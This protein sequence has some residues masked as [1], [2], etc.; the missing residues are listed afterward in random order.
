MAVFQFTA[1]TMTTLDLPQSD[2]DLR[3]S[4][5]ADSGDSPPVEGRRAGGRRRK[6]AEKLKEL[7]SDVSEAK[8]VALVAALQRRRSTTESPAHVGKVQD[9]QARLV[10][11]KR[12]IQMLEA[13][14]QTRT[15]EMS[16][17]VAL[18]KEL[19]WAAAPSA[20]PR[21]LLQEKQRRASELLKELDGTVVSLELQK[22]K[23]RRLREKNRSAMEALRA[24]ESQSREKLESFQKLWAG[25]IAK[26]QEIQR[27]YTA[28]EART[29]ELTEK[30]GLLEQRSRTPAPSPG[31]RGFL[32]EKK[33][34]VS[35]LQ[36]ELVGTNKVLERQRIWNVQLREANWSA[37]EALSA[38][39]SLVQ[40]KLAMVRQLQA[41]LLGKHQEIQVLQAEL[42]RRTQE[43]RD[44]I[45]PGNEQSGGAGPSAG[46]Q[47]SS[48]EKQVSELQDAL[49]AMNSS[50]D[51]QRRKNN[52]LRQ[53]NLRAMEA[54]SA[55]EPT[56]RGKPWNV[57]KAPSGV[58]DQNIQV[59]EEELVN[60]TVPPPEPRT[61]LVE[62]EKHVS[63]L[64]E[65]A[66]AE[67]SVEPQEE[68][69]G[70]LGKLQELQALLVVKDQ[71]IQMLQEELQMTT[72]RLR[73][74]IKRTKQKCPTHQD[75]L[76]SF[77]LWSLRRRMLC[78]VCRRS[79]PRHKTQWR[80]GGKERRSFGRNA[81]R[82]REAARAT[83]S[84]IPGEN[85]MNPG[86]A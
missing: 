30:M 13:E 32:L 51:L 2:E 80:T 52:Q 72:K 28:L 53:K 54:L 58:K 55:S 9:L 22:Q 39:Q 40:G 18:L 27:L 61:V 60:Q 57:R 5:V 36:R 25:L 65:L 50:L 69:R 64:Q 68:R 49:A 84:V 76:Q 34:Q 7:H 37:M 35:E 78:W 83:E 20:G 16:E 15:R 71:K 45:Q 10:V 3:G 43:L 67:G 73:E 8:A 63:D 75:L 74:N 46:L 44:T 29:E 81:G 31:L 85:R 86:N 77:R 48:L 11:K 1:Q 17:K 33:K 41:Q 23:N 14:L 4:S 82:P 62:K 24:A 79:W 38:A 59:P 12:E 56:V 19:S 70:T 42:E 6:K 21:A 26:D 47:M 66:E